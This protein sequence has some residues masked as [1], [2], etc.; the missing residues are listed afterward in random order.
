MGRWWQNTSPSKM[1]SSLTDLLNEKL[2]F[3]IS[4]HGFQPGHSLSAGESGDSLI[5]IK[6]KNLLVQIIRDRGLVSIYFANNGS[7]RELFELSE[8]IEIGTG[9]KHSYQS[10]DPAAIDFLSKNF[11]FINELLVKNLPEAIRKRDFLREETLRSL[12]YSSE[13]EE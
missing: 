13:G 5:E 1:M 2:G 10:T 9:E 7:P 8:L 3:L 6:N 11:D 12:G 4:D